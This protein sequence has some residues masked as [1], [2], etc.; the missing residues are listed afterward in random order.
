MYDKYNSL[1]PFAVGSTKLPKHKGLL[2][3]NTGSAAG[4]TCQAMLSSGITGN[5]F[6]T[7]AASQFNIVPIEVYS[8]TALGVGLTGWLLN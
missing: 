4:I 5:V 3:N 8:V 2:I 6:M 7:M 1:T